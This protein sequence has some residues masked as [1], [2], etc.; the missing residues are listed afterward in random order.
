MR[1]NTGPDSP[2]ATAAWSTWCACAE[3]CAQTPLQQREDAGTAQE[4]HILYVDVH[5]FVFCCSFFPLSHKLLSSHDRDEQK[6]SSASCT[7]SSRSHRFQVHLIF[8]VQ[9]HD[10]GGGGVGGA[11]TGKSSIW[12]A[13]NISPW[14]KNKWKTKETRLS[15]EGSMVRGKSPSQNFTQYR[16]ITCNERIFFFFLC[17]LFSWL[18]ISLNEGCFDINV[19]SCP[20]SWLFLSIVFSLLGKQVE[21][22]VGSLALLRSE[23]TE[24]CFLTMSQKL[25]T[26]K[27]VSSSPRLLEDDFL[28][29]SL[30][31]F[32]FFFLPF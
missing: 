32:F 1:S 23:A 2:G 7:E 20:F 11:K 24:N 28:N 29:S 31:L 27:T 22:H 26:T 9:D 5:G 30:F 8:T 21:V 4:Q 25:K 15:W 13:V 14:K 17:F 18:L 10:V 6:P 16:K 3:A 19:K 12:Q